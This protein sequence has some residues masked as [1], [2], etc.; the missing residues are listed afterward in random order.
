MTISLLGSDLSFFTEALVVFRIAKI[1]I[2]EKMFQRNF[3]V[4]LSYKSYF[5]IF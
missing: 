4:V 3:I 1:D 2:I 5:I